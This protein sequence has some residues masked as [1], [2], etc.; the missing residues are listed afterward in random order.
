MPAPSPEPR[1][2]P[3]PRFAPSPSP[4]RATCGLGLLL[5]RPREAAAHEAPGVL[6][7][8]EL[9]EAGGGELVH[10]LLALRPETQRAAVRPGRAGR[11]PRSTGA[12]AHQVR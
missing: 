2:D 6:L 3:R 9:L 11:L 12:L 7:A 4:G 8:G 10:L 5:L 1:R